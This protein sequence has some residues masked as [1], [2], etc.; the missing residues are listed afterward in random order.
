MTGQ[1][2]IDIEPQQPDRPIPMR[3]IYALRR[4][5]GKDVDWTQG[6]GFLMGEGYTSA[7]LLGPLHPPRRKA[8]V[9]K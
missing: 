9:K 3:A 7:E 1:Q 6:V 2:P 5:H 4:K 8:K